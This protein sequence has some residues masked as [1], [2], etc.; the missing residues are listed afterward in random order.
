M[1][2]EKAWICKRPLDRNLYTQRAFVRYREEN[3]KSLELILGT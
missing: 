1:N 3:Y 2:H